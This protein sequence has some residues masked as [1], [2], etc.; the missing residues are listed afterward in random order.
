MDLKGPQLLKLLNKP[1]IIRKSD[2]Q[3]KDK[4]LKMRMSMKVAILI[5]K[6]KKRR[7][8]KNL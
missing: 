5:T 7:K 3:K 1:R 2:R 8:K 4:T 6:M